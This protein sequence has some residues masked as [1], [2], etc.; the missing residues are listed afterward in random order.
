MS[1]P[2]TRPR[3]WQVLRSE[4]VADCRVF[5]VHARH[6][7]QGEGGPTHTFFAIDC[8]SWVNIVPRTAAGEV[9]M[10]RQF[11]HGKG[12]EVLEIPGGLIDPG[13][14]PAE[15]AA[16][17]LLEET[18]YRGRLRPLGR[19]NPNP[20]LFT[21]ALHVFVA[22][23]CQRV[24]EIHN[25][26]VEETIVELVPEADVPARVAAGEVDHALVLSALYLLHLDDARGR[27]PAAGSCG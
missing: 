5:E 22:E 9:V 4:R 25:D 2:P 27:S 8:A 14:T 23:D 7:Q 1:R 24:A 6:S 11:R 19:A 10:I 3:P 21:N 20:A 17:E 26:A 16:R 13:E 12:G 15:A 18:G